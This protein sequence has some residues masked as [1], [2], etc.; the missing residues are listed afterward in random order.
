MRPKELRECAGKI[1]DRSLDAVSP[2]TAIKSSLQRKKD[3]ITLRI[4]EQ[5]E[6]VIDLK[7]FTRILV[8]GAG[9]ATAAMAKAVEDVL[10]DRISDGMINV[11]YGYT[12]S[13]KKI[14][15]VEAGHPIPDENGA[16]GARKI[17][18]LLKGVDEKTLVI[19]LI[20]GGGS[21]LLPLPA[22]EI[23]LKDKMK[24]TDLLLKCGADIVEINSIRK[25]LSGVK[26]GQLA[27]AAY[28]A[29]VLTF[30]VSDVIGDRLDTIASGPTVPDRT[31]F[32]DA[33]Q[34]FDKYKLWDKL[35]GAVA[36]RIRSGLSGDIEDTPKE[37][38]RVFKKVDNYIVAS[39]IQALKAAKSEAEA[40]GFKA[41]ILSSTIQGETVDIA[42]AHAAIAREI[43]ESGHPVSPPAC[44]I[45]GGETTVTIKGSGKGGRNQ[46][47]ALA[48]ALDIEGLDN[49]VILSL[50][51]DGTDGPTDAAGG[52]VD[53]ETVEKAIEMKIDPLEYLDNNDSYNFLKRLDS[54]I[55]TGPTNTNVMDVRLILVG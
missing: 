43:R 1:I 30:I 42:R 17:V 6:R 8:L 4:N 50:G 33:A 31:T 38:D 48:A 24:V 16:R 51:T 13:L 15:I 37:G 44:I 47:F 55:I 12:E 32:K 27:R 3:I 10:L 7:D 9:K 46:E 52:M 22:G 23:E 41:L 5:D 53:G 45:S 18:S 54:L 14:N 28:P 34:V 20:S 35:P 36:R 2:L 39:N 40:L 29:K 49:I 26:G 25:H 21:A 11:K 19:C